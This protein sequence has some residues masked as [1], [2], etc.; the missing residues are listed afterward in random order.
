M[1]QLKKIPYTFLL[2]VFFTLLIVACKKEGPMGPQGPAGAQGNAG[3]VGPAG[4]NGSIIY[5]GNGTPA[6]TLGANG[7]F[8]IDLS[9]SMLYGPKTAAGWGSGF[10]LKGATG[11]PGA[12]GATGATGAA[13]SKILSGS[14]AHMASPTLLAAILSIPP[15]I[16]SVPIPTS[17]NLSWMVVWWRCISLL[18]KIIPTS[19]NQ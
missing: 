19:G 2:T 8:Y 6:G 7:D 14:G 18:I 3:P 9:S 13:G 16:T 11:A 15:A 1:Y 12:A 10:S 17:R 4:Q 5:S